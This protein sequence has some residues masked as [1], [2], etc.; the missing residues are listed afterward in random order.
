MDVLI[1]THRLLQKDVEFKDLGL[2]VVDEEQRFGVTHKEQLKEICQQVDVL[3]LS[4][5]PIPRTL[6]M[7]LSGIRDMSTLEEPPAGPPAGADLCAGAR[8]GGA[9]R[10][11]APGAGAGA[12]RST[13]STTG[14]RPSTST[15]A[16]IQQHAGGGGAV[17][18]AHGKM[19]Q[20]E[21]D[22]VMQPHGRRGDAD[23]LVCTTIIET[24]IDIAQREHPHHRGRG[25]DGA[26]PAPPDPGP[27]GPLQPPGLC[28]P[29]LPPGQGAAAR[30]RPSG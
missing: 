8:L 5:T 12:G 6:N 9:G 11:H 2:L 20:E 17:A 10:R 27:G 18:V 15:A 19:S 16:R 3:T 7:A 22:D 21:L 30:W 23:V 26:G 4:A 29:H 13:T 28:L 24:G 14:W 1:G 25:Q